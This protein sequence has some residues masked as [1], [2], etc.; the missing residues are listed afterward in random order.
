M[1]CRSWCG[2]LVLIAA[3]Y[4]IYPFVN[5][6]VIGQAST[7]Y[8]R[9]PALLASDPVNRWKRYSGSRR[10]GSTTRRLRNI[11]SRG[12]HAQESPSLTKIKIKIKIPISISQRPATHFIYRSVFARALPQDIVGR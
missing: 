1:I 9:S 11:I 4:T 12:G 7:I 10:K 5:R 3:S 8:T 2:I 6:V